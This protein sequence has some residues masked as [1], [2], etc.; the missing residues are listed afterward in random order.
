MMCYS[1]NNANGDAGCSEVTGD[2]TVLSP[3]WCSA[4][5]PTPTPVG[6]GAGTHG[7]TARMPDVPPS[8]TQ[9]FSPDAPRLLPWELELLKKACR[10]VFSSRLL[11]G[12]SL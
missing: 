1:K 12:S 5:P 6:V 9:G 2:S 10:N 11:H 8:G 3:G 7:S 4:L